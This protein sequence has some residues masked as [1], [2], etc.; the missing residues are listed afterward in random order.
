MNKLALSENEPAIGK[1][2]ALS[3][4]CHKKVSVHPGFSCL[5][6]KKVLLE[7]IEQSVFAEILIYNVIYKLQSLVNR[8]ITNTRQ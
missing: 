5:H 8:I 4:S 6:W 7:L 1:T 2:Y 3:S